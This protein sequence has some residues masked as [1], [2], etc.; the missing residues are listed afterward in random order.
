MEL[1]EDIIVQ[2]SFNGKYVTRATIQKRDINGK[3]K[4]HNVSLIRI[5]LSNKED[6]FALK[7]INDTWKD[8]IFTSDVYDDAK[9]LHDNDIFNS[10]RKFYILTTQKKRFNRLHPDSILA[11][12]GVSVKEF[13]PYVSIEHFETKPEFQFSEHNRLYKK[14]GT[15][16]LNALKKAF[17]DKDITLHSVSSSLD[18][19]K[20]NGFKQLSY[21][22]M[23]L[24]FFRG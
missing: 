23:N 10:G 6:I 24:R 12:T 7:K 15:G 9:Y 4:D 22:S 19:Y 14:V 21:D 20:Y 2:V 3:Y 5:D 8:A 18:F 11:A 1:S 16:L 13:L 17:E